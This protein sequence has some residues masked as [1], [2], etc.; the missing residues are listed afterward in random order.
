MLLV[1][2]AVQPR[3]RRRSCRTPPRCALRSDQACVRRM[4]AEYQ[5]RRDLVLDRLRGIP[6]VEPLRAGGRAVRDGR[7]AAARAAVGRGPSLPAA[8]GRRRRP[9]RGRLRAGRRGDAARLVRGG[10]RAPG[11]GAGAAARRVAPPLGRGPA[12]GGRHE[13]HRVAG[14]RRP[15]RR[16]RGRRGTW[17][18]C[19]PRWPGPSPARSASIDSSRA[20]YSTDASVY[21]IVPLGVVLPRTEADVVAAV[22]A[23]ARFGVPLTARGG[24]TSQAGQSIGP[25]V[26]LDCSKYLNR[27]LEINA[28]ERWVRVEPGCVLDDLNRQLQP[29]GL[30][31]APDIS[32]ANRATIGGMIANNSSGTRSVIYGK[33]IDHVLELKV[34]L[35]DGSVV[36]RAGRST[37]PELEAKCGQEDL[38]GALLPHGPPAG[39]GARRGDRAPLSRRSCAASAATTSTAF[40]AA[41]G[42]ARSTW[43]TCSSARRGRSASSSRP[44]CGWSSCRGPRPCSSC[45]SP[46]CSTPWRPRRPSW[47]T[48]PAAVEVMDRYILDS[49]RLNP[50]AARLRDFLAGRPRGHPDHRVLRRPRRRSCRRGSTRSRPT[51]A[52]GASATTSSGRPTPPR[53]P[54]S[55]SCA[56]LALGLSMAEKGDAKAISFVEDTAVAPEH[57]RDYIA[58]FLADHRPPRH[59]GRRLRP[60][61]GR[62]PARAAR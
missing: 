55:G 42:R 37:R 32:T 10:R 6:G 29:L 52:G 51:C 18:A 7:R 44:S 25:G 3:A 33:T 59:Q 39:R 47:R 23:C 17:R 9:P 30:Q 38:E 22:A 14:D 11:A 40:R 20:L 57:L 62:L 4:A 16:R 15:I 19:T 8:R 60:R 31:F 2:A 58:E 43:P 45:S 61:L 34:V 21:Q 28:A 36:R 12:R 26:I 54:A 1:L 56:T 27:V 35:A 50:E 5:A 53:R 41:A 48:G 13:R 24:G 46:T 49:T